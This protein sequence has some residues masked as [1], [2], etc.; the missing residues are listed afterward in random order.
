VEKLQLNTDLRRAIERGEFVLH[1][2]PKVDLRDGR[3]H[4]VEA[5]L[6]WKHPQRGMVPP[7]EFVPALE[8]SGLILPV[9]EWVLG[10]AARQ[11]GTWHGAGLESVPVAVNLSAKQFRRRDLDA[12]IRGV[13]AVSRVPAGL[14]ELEITESC[15]MDEPE[16]ALRLLGNLRAA[17]LKISVD[18]FGTGYSS[19]SYLTR[20][21]LTALK[22]DRSFVRDVATSSEAASIVRAV[23]DMAHNLGFTVIAE[24]VESYE[25]VAF[26]R[27]HGC[28]LGQ[29]FLFGPPMSAAEM[30]SHLGRA[31]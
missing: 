18:D 25:Q 30:A 19:L 24:G 27:R 28:D 6:R 17:G 3:I 21:P 23:I 29:G 2:Q 8:D 14:I 22:I 26:L 16:E 13:L 10:E 9:G 7:A 31:G 12:L 1:Y 5:L 20:L 15:L 4:G 11:L